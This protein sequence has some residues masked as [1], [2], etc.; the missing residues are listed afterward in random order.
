MSAVDSPTAPAAADPHRHAG[1]R[2]ARATR[3]RRASTGA[4]LTP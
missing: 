2:A 3:R 4:R 1:A